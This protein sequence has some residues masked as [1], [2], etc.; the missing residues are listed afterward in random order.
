[1]AVRGSMWLLHSLCGCCGIYVPPLFNENC[2]TWLEQ[3]SFYVKVWQWYNTTSSEPLLMLPLK[4]KKNHKSHLGAQLEFSLKGMNK[5][6]KGQRRVTATMQYIFV[7]SHLSGLLNAQSIALDT[8]PT[9]LDFIFPSQLSGN[10]VI[11][12][13]YISVT[14]MMQFLTCSL[15]LTHLSI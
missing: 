6:L 11:Y 7:L 12:I 5:K 1:M 9:W 4:K 8:F 15:I 3:D 10:I 14:D 2:L 13:T